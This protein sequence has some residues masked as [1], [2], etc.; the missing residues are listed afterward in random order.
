MMHSR[1]ARTLSALLAGLVLTAGCA[2]FNTYYNAK[3]AFDTAERARNERIKQGQEPDPPNTQQVQ[4]YE[5]A[6]KKCQIILD[7]YPGHSLTDDALFL[8][9]KARFRLQSYRMSIQALDLLMTNFPATPYLEEAIYL[10]AV[11]HLLIG[12]IAGSSDYLSQLQQKFPDSHF[13]AEALRVGG[14]NAMMLEHWEDARDDFAR[15]LK[16]FSDHKEAPQ[17]GYKLAKCLWELHDYDHAR[18]R[19][20]TVIDAGGEDKELVFDARLLMARCLARLGRHEEAA[21]LID[22]L[23]VDA[24]LYGKAGFVTL[25]KAENLITQGR[26]ED[27]APLLETMPDEE[28]KGDV[29]PLS[30]E[31]LGKIYVERGQFE[32][33]RTKIREA[34]RNS[35]VI[36]DFDYCSQ[37][38]AELNRY[39]FANKRL[40]NANEKQ[41]PALKL[42]E[43]NALMF[44]LNKPRQALDLY[45]DVAGTADVDSSAAVRGLYGAIHVYRDLLDLPDS[46]AI[47][48]ERL[49]K[50]H[51]DAPQ[52]YVERQGSDENL[53]SYL[54]A[55][56]ERER[57]AVAD[58]AA[59]VAGGAAAPAAG[60]VAGEEKLPVY[61]GVRF[62]HW[63]ERKLERRG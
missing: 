48:A 10:Q 56:E 11:D 23:G 53:F 43:A 33:A 7:E 12:D 37:L 28:R 60:E 19:L 20:Q 63:R 51:P 45:L 14:E 3:K 55:M 18:D 50:E 25:A 22:E 42:T 32:D 49:E 6:V 40:D 54:M 35:K 8:M 21:K 41:A 1:P 62:S 58:T 26:S 31:M 30:A 47:Y 24:E 29:A 59:V 2:H 38:D 16:R 9:A 57:A 52:A 44:T 15:F 46:A 17:I 4:D 34:L 39:L 36:E 61:H 27:A 13:Q 5:R